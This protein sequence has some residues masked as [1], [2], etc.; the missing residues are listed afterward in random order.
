MKVNPRL[1]DM[2]GEVFTDWIVLHKSG[3]SKRGAAMWLCKCK[4]GEERVVIG[5][6]LR[7]GKSTGCGCSQYS[8]VSKRMKTHGDSKSRLYRIWKAMQ[9][10]VSNKNI[11]GA[12][13]YSGKGIEISWASFDEFK[14]WANSNGYRDNLSIDR[15]DFDLGYSPSNCRWAD[16]KTQSRNR[17]IVLFREDGKPWCEIAEE[18]GITTTLMHG[19]IHEGWPIEHAATAPKGTRL[20]NLI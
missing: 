16:A 12:E 15:I 6:D 8:D 10:R 13:N 4:C 2:S 3:N 17:S 18:N 19:R 5:G 14:Q 9:T 1:I 7:S 11:R 20:K